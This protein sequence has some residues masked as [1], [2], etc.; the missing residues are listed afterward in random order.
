M[1]IVG[2][3]LEELLAAVWPNISSF[4]HECSRQSK[5][6][7]TKIPHTLRDK[8]KSSLLP[9]SREPHPATEKSPWPCLYVAARC[10]MRL[11][12]LP[13]LMEHCCYSMLCMHRVVDQASQVFSY[14]V[15]SANTFK[16]LLR[17]MFN[18][19]LTAD[20]PILTSLLDLLLPMQR[21][22]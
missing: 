15:S 1:A 2:Q 12:L 13:S 3:T 5:L 11:W 4:Q 18:S 9:S 8:A 22:E 6:T 17:D 16:G 21:K 10:Y 20:P 19:L 14:L 7:R